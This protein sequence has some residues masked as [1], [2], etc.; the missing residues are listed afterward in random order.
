VGDS[1]EASKPR[2]AW[3]GYLSVVAVIVLVASSFAI[4]NLRTA[5][6]STPTPGVASVGPRHDMYLGTVAL[7]IQTTNPLQYTL[8]DEYYIVGDVYSFLINYGPNWQLEP[9]LA[10]QWAQTNTNPATWEFHLAHNAYFADPRTCTSDARGHLVNCDTSHPV[11]A[12]DV[13]F[14]FDYVKKNRNQTSYFAPCTEHIAHVDTT[15]ATD[16]Y[17]VRIVYD[18]RYAAAISSITCVPIL[19]Q[20]IWSPAGVDVK[21]DWSNALPIGS[22]PYMV[23]PVGTTFAMVTPPPLILD[24]NP[25]WHGKEVQ[26]RQVFPDTIFYES[27]TA[28][29]AMALDLI[30]GKIDMAIGPSPPDYTGYL[31]GKAGITRQSVADGFEAEQAINVLPD[32]LRAYFASI[33][34]RPLKLGHS[35]P[36]LQNQVVRTAIHMATNRTKMIQ[37]ALNG[38]GTPGDTLMPTSSPLWYAMPPYSPDDKNG[39]GSPYDFPPFT[40]IALEQFPEGDAADAA[41][42]TMLVNAGWAYDCATGNLQTGTEFPLCKAGKTQ[43]LS[44]RFSTFNTEPWWETAARGVIADAQKAGI[45]FTLELL[46]GAQMYNLWYRLDYDVW[47]WDWVWTPITDTSLFL[48]VQTCHGIVTLDND[49]GYCAR[50]A[51][52]KW[53]FDELY[54]Q[55][56]TTTDPVARRALSDQAQQIIY[57]YASY[58][59]PFY[60]DELYAYNQLHFT[61]FVDFSTSRA[62]PPDIGNSPIFG[63]TVYPVDDKPPQYTLPTF[64][65][66]V[67]QPVQF[68]AAAIDPQGGVLRYR[69]DFDAGH[70]SAD[71]TSTVGGSEPGGTGVNNDGIFSNDDQGGNTATPTWTYAAAGTYDVAL[72][73]SQDGGDF[74]TVQRTTVTIRAPATGSP[75][76]NGVSFSPFDPTTYA[77]DI[78]T[79]AASASDPAGLAL[80]QYTWNWG[81]GS[82]VTTTTGPTASHQYG[83]PGTDTAQVTVRNSAGA[84]ATSSTIV[85]VIANVAPFLAPL[86]SQAVQVN[87]AQSFAA[88][89]SDQNTRDVLTYAWDFGDGA[90]ATGNPGTHTYT[91]SNVQYTLKVTVSDGHGHSVPSSATI[92]VV[93]DRNTAPSINVLTSSPSSTW[94]TLPVQITGNVSDPQGNA[95][96]W[97]WD[98][99]NDGI[100]DKSYITPLTSP[101]Q[102]VIRTETYQYA[103]AGSAKAKLTITD[104]PPP[105]QANKTTFTTVTTSVAANTAPTLTA[106]STSPPSSIPG[107]DVTFSST[108]NDVNGDKVSYTWNFGDG[109]TASGQTGFFGGAI[110]GTHA[111]S[112]TGTFEVV[113]SVNDGKGGTAGQAVFTTVSAGGLLRVTT[114]PAVPGKILVDGVPADEWGL[115]WVKTAPGTHTVS[116]GGLNGLGTPADQTVTVTDGATTTVQG[117]Y[118]VNGYLRVIT[119]PAVVSTISVNGVSRDDWGMWTALAPGTYTVHFGLVAAYNPPA[120]QTATVT[121]GVTTTV[122][123]TFTS[124]PTAPGPDPTTFGYLR[125]TTNPATAAQ[126]LVNGV[127]R[128]D[129]GLTWVKLAPGTYTVSFGQGAGYTPPAPKTV[130]VAAGATTTWDAPFVVHGSLQVKTSPALPATIFVNGVP[131]DDWGMWQSMPPGTYKVSFGAVPG[132]VTPA[133]QTATVTAGVTTP[134][135]GTYVTAPVATPLGAETGSASPL[136]SGREAPSLSSVQ[137]PSAQSVASSTPQATSEPYAADG[138]VAARRFDST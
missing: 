68:S 125:V 131:R 105:G 62:V 85:P 135:T 73:V 98:F 95:L 69:W 129:W 8:V 119:N 110:T 93:A 130:T 111:Y 17:F 22:G 70:V 60:R 108:S 16:P 52:G 43:P 88:F 63:Q 78:L 44:F 46:N 137:M 65:G 11:T 1:R 59:L 18:G 71:G 51:S 76:I 121:A 49:N 57:S 39:D 134:I 109:T 32:D 82:P 126:I 90:T 116:F 31:V 102:P 123:G 114:N 25:I 107:Q 64:E 54:N 3:A 97:Q 99:N 66:V 120:D 50:D 23:R 15:P 75:K 81:D 94:T 21:V 86:Q 28:S 127:P 136:A 10:V 83:T 92:N 91:T 72:R 115:T 13:K 96:L 41:A 36:I 38:L 56:L 87:T 58:N 132:Y 4:A 37:T 6:A 103:T 106:L 2:R 5:S 40:S 14:T 122:T 35:N 42:R 101:G 77:G 104:Q 128:D 112:S 67:S 89:A 33:S 7:T 79:L 138:R 19:P 47:L 12:A 133:A 45:Q 118:A 84:T 117:N 34:N 55:T 9:D 100:I 48:I 29:G 113:L 74:F 26:G 24:R 27:Y 80:T 30:L 53:T 20:Y 124:N 61:N